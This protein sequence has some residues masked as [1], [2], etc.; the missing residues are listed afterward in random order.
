MVPTA[1]IFLSQMIF[2]SVFNG[3]IQCLKGLNS[4]SQLKYIHKILVLN[5]IFYF[6]QYPKI[7]NILVTH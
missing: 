7:Q 3:N 1:K 4:H 2:Y 5:L 6:I